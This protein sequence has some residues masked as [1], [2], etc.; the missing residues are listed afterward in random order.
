MLY[1]GAIRFLRQSIDAVEARDL[2][3]KRQSVDRVMAIIQHLHDT[4]DMD[5]GGS[6]AA[7]LD[8]LYTYITSRILDG[9]GTLETKPLEEAIKL[10]ST[11]LAGWEEV[12]KREQEHAVPTDLLVQ[13][14][15]GRRIELHA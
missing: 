10:L 7:D 15:A 14:A 5:K 2:D 6:V 3:R 13:Q 9:S 11:L 1:E 4:L 12:V 8:R